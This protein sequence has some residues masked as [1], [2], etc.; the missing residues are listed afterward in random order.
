[1]EEKTYIFEGK[2]TNEAI[3]KGLKELNVPK[4]KV[5][6]KVLE[7]EEKR[8]FFSILTPRVV[9]VEMTLKENDEVQ[10]KHIH[11]NDEKSHKKE[12]VEINK[13]EITEKLKN[14]L[15]EFIEK[16]PKSD[17]TYEIKVVENDFHI[18]I[19]GENTGYLIGYRGEVLNSLQLILTN[20]ASKDFNC[21]VKVLLNIGGYREK[22]E[23]DLENLAVKI[24]GSV[25]KSR[26]TITL[27]PMSAY[28]RKI[29][30][31]KLQDNDKVQTHSIGEEPYRKVVVSLKK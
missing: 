24:A 1:M 8:S 29:I 15:D 22:R 3:E 27:E 31:L 12:L 2:T 4:N 30:H 19:N 20:I 13:E 14:F 9:K 6:I 10:E 11:N 26:K 17:L 23:K 16:L 21:K 28:E 7:S 25:I 5:E 18:D